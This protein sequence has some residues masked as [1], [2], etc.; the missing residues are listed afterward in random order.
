MDSK[1]M[2]AYEENAGKIARKIIEDEWLATGVTKEELKQ[3]EQLVQLLGR[4]MA[5]GRSFENIMAEWE[6]KSPGDIL[7]EYAAPTPVLHSA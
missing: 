6:G 3:D 5:N 4:L 7:R 2:S 1:E